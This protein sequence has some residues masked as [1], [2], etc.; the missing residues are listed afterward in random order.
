MSQTQTLSGTTRTTLDYGAKTEPAIG[1][2]SRP[3]PEVFRTWLPAFV[4]LV[5]MPV[6]ALFA[7]KYV[8]IPSIKDTATQTAKL[9]AEADGLAAEAP[10]VFAKVPFSVPAVKGAHSGV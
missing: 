3:I 6:L 5:G 7:T 4:I 10:L 2:I 1:I 8:V 9:R